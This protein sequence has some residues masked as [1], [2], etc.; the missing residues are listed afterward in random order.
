M[1]RLMS[2]ILFLTMVVILI[3]C[4]GMQ[5]QQPSNSDS[6]KNAA[7]NA[8]FVGDVGVAFQDNPALRMIS[9]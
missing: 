9:P 2:L 4:A 7:G 8:P 1:K 5:V 3:G 6:F